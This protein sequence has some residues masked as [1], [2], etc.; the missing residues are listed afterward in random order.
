MSET[1]LSN[2][3]SIAPTRNPSEGEIVVQESVVELPWPIWNSGPAEMCIN[4]I[5]IST[6]FQNVHVQ[7]ETLKTLV[8]ER[9]VEPSKPEIN[10]EEIVGEVS[11]IWVQEKQQLEAR[12]LALETAIEQGETK[13]AER[14]T[15][16]LQKIN[17]DIS[18]QQEE[19][20]LKMKKVISTSIQA[21][22]SEIHKEMSVASDKIELNFGGRINANRDNI[23][24]L[25]SA[26]DKLKLEFESKNVEFKLKHD[27]IDLK[28]A[29][30]DARFEA[31]DI[32]SV[33]V[34]ALKNHNGLIQEELDYIGP[35][36][37]SSAV[38]DLTAR[39]EAI[40]KVN[41]SLRRQC[42]NIASMNDRIREELSIYMQRF[43]QA[44]ND[45]NKLTSTVQSVNSNV[46]GLVLGT[47]PDINNQIIDI[48]LKKADL[49]DVKGKADIAYVDEAREFDGELTA[50]LQRKINHLQDALLKQDEL[51][52][53]MPIELYRNLDNKVS[54]LTK[55]CETQ[56]RANNE[57]L[58]N[59]QNA[60]T[61]ETSAFPS[62]TGAQSAVGV[63][64][65][66]CKQPVVNINHDT[67]K[68]HDHML[69]TSTLPGREGSPTQHKRE[70]HTPYFNA[71]TT[72]VGED[73]QKLLQ[74]M[75]DTAAESNKSNPQQP[76]KFSKLVRLLA[77]TNEQVEHQSPVGKTGGSTLGSFND[78]AV[79]HMT[80]EEPISAA[81]LTV[82]ED[83]QYRSPLDT[84]Y[85]N[86]VASS[87]IPGGKIPLLSQIQSSHKKKDFVSWR[88]LMA[89]PSKKAI[90]KVLHPGSSK[91]QIVKTLS[92]SQFAEV[93]RGLHGPGAGTT[94]V[95]SHSAVHSPAGSGTMSRTNGVI[96]HIPGGAV[97]GASR[98]TRPT[99]APATRRNA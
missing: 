38:M 28:I 92:D 14:E 13:A 80:D 93:N 27:D 68:E 60:K 49:A 58:F 33:D 42:S 64:C 82:M 74:S 96:H 16:F 7:L 63:R 98:A 94:V 81:G 57:M 54:E 73:Q 89:D 44:E 87:S 19:F 86:L 23:S 59:F 79:S 39:C 45:R 83:G 97:Q 2:P 32:L 17:G 34:Q 11:K 67:G 30:L 8:S 25:I 31:V 22:S 12:I 24:L 35:I 75:M 3:G 90:D 69:L 91:M 9:T 61:N 77:V 5:P 47:I 65:L 51:V 72:V 56:I 62:Q 29:G 46:N 1:S 43:K 37:R 4:G 41:E 78:T 48:I 21:I 6:V 66:S 70:T 85:T 50:E 55:W 20:E 95:N 53:E 76:P 71:N 26:A 15:K 18:I 10:V 84:S 40:E 88:P 52:T 36:V 99:S